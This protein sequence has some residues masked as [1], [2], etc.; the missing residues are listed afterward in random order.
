MGDRISIQFKTGNQ[1]SVVLFSQWG[2][3]A[4]LEEAKKY[5][6]SLREEARSRG[7]RG[8]LYRLEPNTVMV[9]FIRRLTREEARVT[10]DL[11]LGA[12][13]MDGDN[14]DNGNHVIDLGAP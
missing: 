9:D 6:R 7:G 2:G 1:R 3:Q 12:T 13:L 5:A 10:S 4:F 11:Y 8:P 14:Y